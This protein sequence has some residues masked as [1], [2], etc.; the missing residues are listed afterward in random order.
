MNIEINTYSIR[1]RLEK[2]VR[3]ETAHLATLKS[4]KYKLITFL[5]TLQRLEQEWQKSPA[6]RP[7]Y[8]TAKN[9][10]GLEK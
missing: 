7:Y 5:E 6:L 3:E 8:Q 9:R 4:L 1:K 10:F 2:C